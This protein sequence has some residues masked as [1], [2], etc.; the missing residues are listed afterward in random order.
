MRAEFYFF[1]DTLICGTCRCVE[2]GANADLDCA[3]NSAELNEKIPPAFIVQKNHNWH[4]FLL[5]K[6]KN[7]I[8]IEMTVLEHGTS[9]F[10]ES[11]WRI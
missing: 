8:I 1:Q 9:L 10:L 6:C 7:E 2:F 3:R 5:T 4:I 11:V